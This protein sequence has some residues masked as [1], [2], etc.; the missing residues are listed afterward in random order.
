MET[1]AGR[2]HPRTRQ[3]IPMAAA[4]RR[5][6]RR[7]DAPT[8]AQIAAGEVV[9]RPASVVKELIENAI[10]AH[11]RE[12]RILLRGGGIGSIEVADDGE[13][14]LPSELAIALER[15]ATS[16]LG[17]ADDLAKVRSLGFRGE[18]LAAIAAV[19]R[20]TITSRPPSQESAKGI[21]VEDGRPPRTFDAGRPVGTTV[22][23]EDLFY[24]TPARW[25]FLKSPVGEAQGT[26][27]TVERLY[28]ARPDVGLAIHGENGEIARFPP[29]E[30]LTEAAA[31]VLGP[32]LIPQALSLA[33]RLAD[34]VEV[35]G[36]VAHPALFR[37]NSL[38]IHLVVNGRAIVS[39]NLTEAV[40][41]A[42]RDYLPRSKFPV[43]VL[44]LTMDLDR[45]DVNVHPTKR[46]IRIAR[47]RE[48]ADIPLPRDPRAAL[49][50]AEPVR[51]GRALSRARILPSVSP[52]DVR[53]SLPE[54]IRIAS[55]RSSAAAQRTLPISTPGLSRPMIT[56]RSRPRLLG[57]VFHLYWIAE[58][59]EGLMLIDQHAASERLLYD[60]LIENGKLARQEL[61]E[62]VPIP[63]TARRVATLEA[64][65]AEIS[66]AGF[67]VEP[68]GK[69]IYRL[70]SVPVYRGYSPPPDTIGELLDELASGGRPT[71]PNGLI[72][73]RAASIACHAAIRGGDAVSA[74]AMG[75]VLDG[76][77]ALPDG[78][79]ACPHGRPI[80][81]LL[82]RSRLDRWFLRPSA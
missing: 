23:V 73:R 39:R 45:L 77:S 76:L 10:D 11:A 6:I 16:K 46:E 22:L 4:D 57:E 25:K 72:E 75:R 68:F 54:K 71:V 49:E 61:V 59:E 12:V 60:A 28:L 5:P 26:I 52:L 64:Q 27:Q 21:H 82:P 53:I 38:G 40:R 79:Y 78:A 58:G 44:H 70:L 17:S 43:A 3:V 29:T 63:L 36:V 35:R 7:L 31:R 62:P 14:I 50:R 69:G 8:I 56:S 19:A 65:Q 51:P 67:T 30:D 32:E 48:L 9:D 81:V 2:G 42:Y 13:G 41:Q 66:A 74:E 55:A 20:L 15:H 34:L 37:S 80:R 24:N 1:P 33:V 47:E 18:A